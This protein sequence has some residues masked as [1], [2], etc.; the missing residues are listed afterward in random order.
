MI[1]DMEKDIELPLK[2]G[3]ERA[4]AQEGPWKWFTTSDLGF[5]LVDDDYNRPMHPLVESYVR[6]CLQDPR[7]L[8]DNEEAGQC[9]DDMAHS[10]PEWMQHMLE[11]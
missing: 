4:T 9:C 2:K 10:L 11:D 8:D 1:H 3:A 6:D 5:L 7:M